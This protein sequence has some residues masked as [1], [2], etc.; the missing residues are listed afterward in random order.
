[1]KIPINL[2]THKIPKMCRKKVSKTAAQYGRINNSRDMQYRKH[3]VHIE[4][5]RPDKCKS[6]KHANNKA[7]SFT[8]NYKMIIQILK[9][10][11]VF[12]TI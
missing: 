2:T 1:M 3:G 6:R 8:Y 9:S 4:L 5:I 12:L 7:G 10:L 11:R